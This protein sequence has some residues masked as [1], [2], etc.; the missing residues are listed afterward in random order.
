MEA[1]LNFDIWAA[2]RGEARRDALQADLL[3]GGHL[4]LACLDL[5]GEPCRTLIS[6]VIGMPLSVSQPLMPRHVLGETHRLSA[7]RLPMEPVQEMKDWTALI[8]P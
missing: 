1:S 3:A 7:L 8:L 4:D 6:Q 5:P 2:Y